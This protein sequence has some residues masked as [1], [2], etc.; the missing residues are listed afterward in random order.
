M[1]HRKFVLVL[2]CSL[3]FCVNAIAQST[4]TPAPGSAERQAILDALRVPAEKDL[5]RPVIF[6]V[7]LLSVAGKWAFARV[8]PT[9]PN[10]GEI[11]Y[12]RTKYRQ[13]VELGAFDAQGEA[14]LRR[15]GDEWKVLEWRFG[16]TDTETPLWA[17]KYRTP[18]AL[19]K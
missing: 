11:D 13:Q 6:K 9:L 1:L 2:G 12:S 5:G 10:G 17:E 14:L 18:K 3:F 7:D 16:A 4:H 15:E 8:F 19:L